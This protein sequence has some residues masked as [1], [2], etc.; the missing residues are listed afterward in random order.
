MTVSLEANSPAAGFLV[1]LSGAL[2]A[3]TEAATVTDKAQES[4]LSERGALGILR[5]LFGLP[6]RPRCGAP[7]LV[8]GSSQ[9]P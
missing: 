7:P 3:T 4:Q 9:M 6:L 1:P 8:S 2:E 5:P